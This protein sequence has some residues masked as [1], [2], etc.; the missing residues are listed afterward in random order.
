MK[1]IIL[2]QREE[3]DKLLSIEYQERI[4]QPF[5]IE[6]RDSKPIKLIVGP[7]RAGKSVL[8]LQMLKGCNFAYL[9]F[10]DMQLLAKFNEDVVSQVLS[11]VYPGYDYLL[12][13]EVQNLEGWSLW[14]QKLY[15]RGINLIITGSN[16]NLLSDDLSAH[17][18]GR[19][20]EIRLFPFSATE[21]SN[22]IGA[23][24][25]MDTPDEIAATNNVLDGFMRY[26]GYPEVS[27]TPTIT[28]SYLYSLYDT[29]ILKD[30]VKR[31]KVRNVV[32]L[33]GIADWLLA[34][35]TNPFSA[36]SIAADLDMHSIT[37]VQKFLG[38]LQNC[39]L[40]QYLP[41]FNNKLKLMHKADRKAYVIDNGFVMARAFTLSQN[42]GRLLENMVFME[43]QKQGYNLK[44]YEL[45]YYRTRN[46]REVDFVCRKG[47]SVHEL[48]QVCYDM[49]GRTTR[50]RE[51][52]A[53]VEAAGE[54]HNKNLAVITWDQEE[55]VVQDGYTI[56]VVPIRKWVNSCPSL[57]QMVP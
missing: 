2:Q 39:Y 22:Y 40:F 56:R 45:F 55:T 21:H 7:R 41:R 35:F 34:N 33:S 12:L 16:A 42:S 25:R 23:S 38:Y 30:I 26:G 3:R 29:I 43:L 27:L 47:T 19:F 48:I 15:R 57:Y 20:V 10:D 46:D 24:I 36:N 9:N 52:D 49:S 28:Q 54:L 1:S 13:D 11:E 17:L 51:L 14:V 31:Y 6:I 5:A 44:T 8:A 18:T 50:K 37:S 4:A 32:E 53:I